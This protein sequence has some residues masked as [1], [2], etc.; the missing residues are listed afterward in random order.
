[1]FPEVRLASDGYRYLDMN[2][3][4]RRCRARKDFYKPRVCEDQVQCIVKLTNQCEVRFPLRFLFDFLYLAFDEV[5]V[6]RRLENWGVV[7]GEFLMDNELFITLSRTSSAGFLTTKVGGHHVHFPFFERRVN[8]K[9]NILFVLS[10]AR[11]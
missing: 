4:I 1:M 8:D 5:A 9:K 7:T 2:C 10:Q 6:E 11:N 3:C